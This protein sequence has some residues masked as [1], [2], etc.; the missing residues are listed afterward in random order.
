[1]MV[2][3]AILTVTLLGLGILGRAKMTGIERI[4]NKVNQWMNKW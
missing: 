4:F 1:M 3:L 2:E